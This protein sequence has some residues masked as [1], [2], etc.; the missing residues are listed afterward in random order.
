MFEVFASSICLEKITGIDLIM[1]EV[2]DVEAFDM[3]E[4][5]NDESEDDF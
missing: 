5:Y 1:H 3:P 4:E 2:D